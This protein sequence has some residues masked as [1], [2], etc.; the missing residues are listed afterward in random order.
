MNVIRIDGNSAFLEYDKNQTALQLIETGEKIDH[1]TAFGRVAFSLPGTHLLQ[2]EKD[3]KKA[4]HTILTPY[5]KLDTPGKTTVAVVILADPDGHEIC[6]VEDETFRN[7]SAIDPKVTE[8]LEKALTEDKSDEWYRNK[9]KQK[10][11]A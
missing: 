1:G 6:Y 3:V 2:L 8:L 9:G 5:V 7:L 10:C 11:E 4:G